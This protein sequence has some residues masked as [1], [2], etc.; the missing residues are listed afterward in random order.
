MP[1]FP[2]T[3][4]GPGASNSPHVRNRKL[5]HFYRVQ[6]NNYSRAKVG[7]MACGVESN[8]R[9]RVCEGREGGKTG[10]REN[11]GGRDTGASITVN[12]HSLVKVGLI[13]MADD[14]DKYSSEKMKG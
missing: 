7:L 3:P 4:L 2:P 9:R 14:S 5:P 6:K 10:R 8:E 11:K 13:M 12:N 1:P